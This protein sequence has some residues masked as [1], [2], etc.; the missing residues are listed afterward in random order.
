MYIEAQLPGFRYIALANPLKRNHTLIRLMESVQMIKVKG[1]TAK[2]KQVYCFGKY[3]VL[4]NPVTDPIQHCCVLGQKIGSFENN[5][6]IET[7][8][9]G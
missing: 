7:G 4:E 2:T 5:E 6:H 1:L 3:T 8:I 9:F